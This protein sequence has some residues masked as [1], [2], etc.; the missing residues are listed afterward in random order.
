MHSNKKCLDNR[1]AILYY[2]DSKITLNDKDC[3]Y[4]LLA[5]IRRRIV[6]RVIS[7]GLPA[8]TFLV[9]NPLTE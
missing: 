9:S 7:H 8:A 1:S 4:Q 6:A 3:R 2:Y 5:V